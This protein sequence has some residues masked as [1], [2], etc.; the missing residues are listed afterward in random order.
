METRANAKGR[1]WR[2]IAIRVSACLA[3]ASLAAVG[4]GYLI[5][6]TGQYAGP[7]FA[8]V[9]AS[10]SRTETALVD[11]NG[12]ILHEQRTE[13]QGR[14]LEWTPLDQVSPALTAAVLAAEDQR[15]HQHHGVDFAALARASLG[16]LQSGG[17]G[18]STISMQLAARLDP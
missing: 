16:L 4:I 11:R 3:A 12:E 10:H 17:R 13:S 6:Q 18:A 8:E 15:F 9:Q 2:R 5:L 7:S 14:R 1:G